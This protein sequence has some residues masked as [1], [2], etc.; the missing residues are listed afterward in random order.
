MAHAHFASLPDAAFRLAVIEALRTAARTEIDG[1]RITRDTVART[2]VLAL[3]TAQ[4]L[5]PVDAEAIAGRLED[6][7]KR[8]H[9][10]NQPR[11]FTTGE[12]ADVM[13]IESAIWDLVRR[14]VVYP[15]MNITV[16]V[17][18]IDPKNPPWSIQW[19]V[20]TQ[21]GARLIQQQVAHP[22]HPD[23]VARV[24]DACPDL[25]PEVLARLED[26]HDCFGS[27]LHRAA[28]VMLRLAYEHMIRVIYDEHDIEKHVP[29]SLKPGKRAGASVLL[30]GIVHVLRH[31]SEPPE[32]IAN[33]AMH[34]A[35]VIRQ[36]GNAAAHD[37]ARDFGDAGEVEEL[38]I[39]AGRN[40]K[41]LWGLKDR[42]P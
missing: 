14:G 9:Q 29:G 5:A 41:R 10:D 21:L 24:L 26:A 2:A 19:L 32:G 33:M 27:G 42:L 6:Y 38:L 17:S 4:G 20:L 13:R 34:V 36:D 35:D 22:S 18:P 11:G 39:L 37:W 30:D 31:V 1:R 25:P 16:Q 15:R 40:V 3:A 12:Q 7:Y 23:F 28:V 8:F